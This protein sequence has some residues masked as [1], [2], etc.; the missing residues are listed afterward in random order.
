MLSA[1]SLQ[2]GSGLC[3]ALLPVLW[4]RIGSDPSPGLPEIW[5]GA[6]A[7][8][9]RGRPRGAAFNPQAAKAPLATTKLEG[10]EG[11][12]VGPPSHLKSVAAGTAVLVRNQTPPWDVKVGILHTH[13]TAVA[14]RNLTPPWDAKVDIPKMRDREEDPTPDHREHAQEDTRKDQTDNEDPIRDNRDAID[15]KV[16]PSEAH[17]PASE[18]MGAGM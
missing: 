15:R 9:V 8:K 6:L 13:G 18:R 10:G 5:G 2:A 11:D 16:R 1:W 14:V 17:S 3:C 12:R 7:V 4:L